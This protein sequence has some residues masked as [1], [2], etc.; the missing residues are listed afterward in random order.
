MAVNLSP[1][2]GAGWQFFDNNG[3]ILSGGL[4]YTYAAGTTTP[5]ATYTSSGGGTANTNPIVLDSAGR[6]SGEIWLTS[7][8][9]YKFVL[10][11]STGTTIGTYDNIISVPASVTT[12][13][14]ALQA[15]DTT[16]ALKGANTDITSLASP[17]I[18]A[19]T[20]TTATAGDNT[21]K[22]ATTAF[23][24]TAVSTAVGSDIISLPN[25][26]VDGTGAMTLPASTSS[27]TL[28]F[29]STTA[30]SG[31]AT[32][33]TGTPAA[34][35]IT[36]GATLGTIN[37][38]KSTIVEVLINNAGTLEPAIVNLY[39]G[40]DLSE[41]G[42]ISTTAMN[43]SSDSANVFYSTTARTNV[44]YRVVR[45]ITSTQA[46]AGSWLTLPSAVQ[47]AGGNALTAMSSLGYGQTY[48]SF[49]PTYGTVYYNTSGRTQYLILIC[50][51]NSGSTPQ[52]Y[53]NGVSVANGS[54][55]VVSQALTY[56]AILPAWCSWQWT[57]G[58]SST[59]LSAS[60]LS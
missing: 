9:S 38:V 30:S 55:G 29:R 28:A 6:V 34:L 7:N 49:T 10:K 39:G 54:S 43:S 23:V 52:L 27:I 12:D 57:G 41:T 17:A 44:A 3:V 14:A 60:I 50:Q 26:T 42:L 25:P 35:V 31:L 45:T 20:A 51:L 40:N 4:L 58:G 36:N 13:I 5:Q 19:A 56:P 59:L 15:A 22:V 48:G 46:T 33:V 16:F 53:V 32:T 47:G 24:N 2:A 11:N 8:L 21:T 1:F 37:G 18:G